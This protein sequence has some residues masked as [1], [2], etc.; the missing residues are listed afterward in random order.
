MAPWE[1]YGGAPAAP[2][3]PQ[4]PGVI[5]GRPKAPDPYRVDQDSI[6]NSN[7]A[8]RL[9]LAQQAAAIAAE[10][11]DAD[12]RKREVTGG[13]ESVGEE[14]TAAYL[15]TRLVDSARA[16]RQY[17]G[18]R[19][20]L[21]VELVRGLGGEKGEWA[22]NSMT[23]ADRQ[24]VETNQLDI[25]DSALTL[26]TGAAYT[27]EQLEGYRKTYFPQIGD[28]EPVIKEKA[29]K[30][31][32]LMQAARLKAGSA[33]PLID[34]ALAAFTEGDGGNRVGETADMA[35]SA[36]TT[37]QTAA[38]DPNSPAAR[39]A[40]EAGSQASVL[41]PAAGRAATAQ[42]NAALEPGQSFAYDASGNP[43]GILDANGEWVSGYS[44]IT[45]NVSE[46]QAEETAAERYGDDYGTRASSIIKGA[47]LNL[48]DEIAGV[49]GG[50]YDTLTGGSFAE[51][52]R[53]ERDVERAVQK[54]SRNDY[55]IGWELAG[56]LL[57]PGLLLK[58]PKT[59]GQFAGQGAALGAGAGYG[60]GEG[61]VNSGVNALAGAGVGLVA[62]AGAGKL[63]EKLAT[64]KTA[65]VTRQAER[66]AL[67]QDFQAEDVRALPANVG[68]T[69][70]NRMTGG[71]AQAPIGGG[72]IR[73]GA[74]E[75]AR[76]FRGA[77]QGAAARSGRS[78]EPDDAGNA[79]RAAAREGI[80]R[81]SER[82]GRIYKAAEKEAEGV[83][84]KPNQ[85]IRQID[86]EI[87]DLSET[88]DIN[89]PLI[90]ELEK[91]KA[92]LVQNPAMS[93][94]G[95]KNARRFAGK[96]ASNPD[97][98]S[99]P[100]K[101]TMARVFDALAK[102]FDGGLRSAGRGRAA[103][104][105]NRADKMWKERIED[106]DGAWEPIIGA[107]KSGEDIVKSIETMAT[108]GKGGFARLKTILSGASEADRGDMIATLINRMGAATKGAQGADVDNY[109]ANTFLTNWAGMSR[110]AKALMFGNSDLRQSLDR[111]AR[112]SES[113]KETGKFANTSN[114]SGAAFAQALAGAGALSLGNLPGLAL[115]AGS[116]YL[117]AGL[118]ASPK[119][120]AW[121]AKAPKNATPE[122]A[123][124]YVG[125]LR[126]LAA[127]EPAIAGDVTKFAQ[128]MNAAND[129]SPNVAVASPEGKQKDD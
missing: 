69:M 114:S 62:G 124:T 17:Q 22:A 123:K 96:A 89:Q 27:K 58:A 110:K 32:V 15:A 21:G 9:R 29:R 24:V 67:M 77:V 55:G 85:G 42:D 93:I 106:I 19:P 128:F 107:G 119:F 47:S 113:V 108:G 120:A 70:T 49:G 73:E 121:L 31:E 74:K 64:R 98:R 13:I 100:A 20:S 10:K 65:N 7:E 112:I 37:A 122:A 78:M 81:N 40:L 127:A 1:K 8:E 79:F 38:T 71:M 25:L 6:S 129:V 14:K 56:G 11:A 95:L 86:D 82:I 97:L 36:F 51:G 45:D 99:T 41:D 125:R 102:D 34:Q 94:S 104:L 80:E 23:D 91:L 4:A 84:I 2:S 116:T 33:A 50:I 117:T 30:L 35:L 44:Q 18:S 3:A 60:E 90:T 53:R 66:N 39:A 68:G 111:L 61:A 88:R 63:S 72:F 103:T 26:G 52:Y 16:L 101:A 83:K 46:R 48:S 5:M 115:A 92:S 12:R 75:Q 59:T 105:F 43:I 76:D 57:T 126:G 54:K 28:K 109:S 118:L 87:A